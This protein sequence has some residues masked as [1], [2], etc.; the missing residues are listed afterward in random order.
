LTYY[1]SK[2]AKFDISELDIITMMDERSA[3]D[4]QVVGLK[5]DTFFIVPISF[6]SN[7]HDYFPYILSFF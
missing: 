2:P 1:W 7:M 6:F 3:H 4:G 5:K